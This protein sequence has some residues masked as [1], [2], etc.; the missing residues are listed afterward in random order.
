MKHFTIYFA[1]LASIPSLSYALNADGCFQLYRPSVMYPIICVDGS[2]EEGI[3]GRGARVALV[4]PNSLVVRKCL[5]T[6]SIR[7]EG[8]PETNKTTFFF[9]NSETVR[10]N[11][12]INPQSNNE[13]GTVTIGSTALNYVRLA[14][15]SRILRAVY[16]SGK[17]EQQ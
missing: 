17:C 2:N 3:G 5:L 4:G 8:T 13:E 15:P 1:L 10:F 12:A 7:F 16:D 11:G 9:E 14:D 6:K